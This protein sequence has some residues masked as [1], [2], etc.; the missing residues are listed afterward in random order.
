M[1]Y[2]RT[3]EQAIAVQPSPA[4]IAQTVETGELALARARALK[5]TIDALISEFFVMGQDIIHIPGIDKPVLSQAAGE[6]IMTLMGLTEQ[7]EDIHVERH[8]DA[9]NP[10]F[11]FEVRCRLVHTASGAVVAEGRAVAHTGESSFKRIRDRSCPDCGAD[12]TIKRSRFENRQTGEKGWYCHSKIGGCG[13]EFRFR[14]ERITAQPRNEE[15]P[16]FVLNSVNRCRKIADKRAM[17]KA[18]LKVGMLSNR[19]TTDLD[20]NAQ[21]APPPPRHPNTQPPRQTPP[22]PA[23]KYGEEKLYG[24]QVTYTGKPRGGQ[25]LTG[26][27]PP[28]RSIGRDP[29][30]EKL[31]AISMATNLSSRQIYERL[32]VKHIREWQD[33]AESAIALIRAMQPNGSADANPADDQGMPLPPADTPF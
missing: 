11:Y 10:F 8:F 27:A 31:R 16:Q 14:D 32:E 18:V 25:T 3:D 6:K 1:H 23:K 20:E 22:P 2:H 5:E 21:S 33:T 9:K 12:G 13:A 24:D 29:D 7:Y 4:V 15:D 30:T 19:F 28:T 17:M 26:E